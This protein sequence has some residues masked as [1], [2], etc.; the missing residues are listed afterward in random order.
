MFSLV[1]HLLLSSYAERINM[2]IVSV[3]KTACLSKGL[4]SVVVN[5]QSAWPHI[6]GISFKQAP[7][8]LSQ[9]PHS[10]SHCRPDRS[11]DCCPGSDVHCCRCPTCHI[12]VARR[13]LD[14]NFEDIC[15]D[16][17]GIRSSLG[18]CCSPLRD[19]LRSC[20]AC[21]VPGAASNK[22]PAGALCPDSPQVIQIAQVRAVRNPC[23]VFSLP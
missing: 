3:L 2:S 5:P 23:G 17:G 16:E 22:A 14:S 18:E 11:S 20:L 10:G 19:R 21:N 15:D 12:A 9:P 6:S 4:H 1:Q 7:D 8:K 13:R